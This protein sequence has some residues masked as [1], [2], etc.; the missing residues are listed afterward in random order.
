MTKSHLF[1]PPI[2]WRWT[3]CLPFPGRID[4]AGVIHIGFSWAFDISLSQ[5]GPEIP[6][7]PFRQLYFLLFHLFLVCDRDRRSL[8]F[9]SHPTERGLYHSS[10]IYLCSFSGPFLFLGKG[11]KRRVYGVSHWYNF[12]FLFCSSFFLPFF[13][14]PRPPTP[15]IARKRRM[16]TLFFVSVFLF[17]PFLRAVSFEQ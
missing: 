13:G 8:G 9:L 12:F 16:G 11:D 1:W 3:S 2:S 4:I 6:L 17:F 7:V 10:F 14:S 15:A 5:L